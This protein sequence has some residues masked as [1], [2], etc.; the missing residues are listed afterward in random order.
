MIRIHKKIDAILVEHY[1]AN[2]SVASICA[3]SVA[4]SIHLFDAD[5]TIHQHVIRY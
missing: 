5:E 4:V 1:K 2:S 3:G